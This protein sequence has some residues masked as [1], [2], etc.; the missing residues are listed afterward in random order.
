[1]REHCNATDEDKFAA[2]CTMRA[3]R[4]SEM[5][6]DPSL[7]GFL[8][9]VL[10]LEQLKSHLWEIK[11]RVDWKRY[12]SNFLTTRAQ[13]PLPQRYWGAGMS[14]MRERVTQRLWDWIRALKSTK[15]RFG[16]R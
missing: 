16:W 1:M 14:T 4:R 6:P 7:P 5:N 12:A 9:S 13:L 15:L 8:A 10:H 11:N 2:Y 3:S